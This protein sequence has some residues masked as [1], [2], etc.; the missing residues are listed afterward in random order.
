MS[1]DFTTSP[2]ELPQFA[3]LE[4]PGLFLVVEGTDGAGKTTLKA[5]LSRRLTDAGHDVL[6]TFQPTP[7][8]R[9]H[10]VF[11]GF[12]E[13][14]SA[15]QQMYRALYLLTLGDRLYHAHA[16]MMP[17]LKAGGIVICDR[18]LYTTLANMAARAQMLEG[19]FTEAAN[20]L[21]QPDLAILVHCPLETAVKRIRA[22]PEEADRPIDLDHMGRVY[23]GF[24]QLETAGHLRG[25]D[26]SATDIEE[27]AETALRW[28]NEALAGK[29]LR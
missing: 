28:V 23:Q 3:K 12:S 16:V 24:R 9:A 15:V 17:Y 13:S 14:G 26:T 20:H 10:E 18:Y 5:Q 11:R 7:S 21:P 27:T 4:A 29:T 1:L 25:I 2:P 8:A 22:R 6:E 19:W